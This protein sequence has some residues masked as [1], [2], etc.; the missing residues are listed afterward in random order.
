MRIIEFHNY[1][2]GCLDYELNPE[3][4]GFKHNI[5]KDYHL[6]IVWEG[7]LNKKADVTS[8]LKEK[9][10]II[11]QVEVVWSKSKIYENV[12]RFYKNEQSS[13]IT[14]HCK[15][16][17]RDGRFYCIVVEDKQ[18]VYNY[19]QNVSGSIRIVNTSILDTKRRL[20]EMLDGNYIHSSGCPEEFY[21]QLFLL[22]DDK[23]IKSVF[24]TN[25]KEH[26]IKVEQDLV[27]SNG[28]LDFEQFFNVINKC[29]NYL[30]QRN[31]EY[32][33][34]DFFGNDT[35]VDILCENYKEFLLA[36][37]GRGIKNKSRIVN[38]INIDNVSVQ[39]DIRCVS[40]KYY[41]PIW[42]A[43]MLKNKELFNK[44]VFS[45]SRYD[46]F[47]SL[48]YHSVIQKPKV[49]DVYVERLEGL[50]EKMGLDFFSKQSFTS[51]EIK[52]KIVSGYLGENGYKIYEAED[53][54]VYL[55]RN[56]LKFM[57][58]DLIAFKLVGTVEIIKKYT[59]K[60]LLKFTP[61]PLKSLIKRII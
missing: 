26:V 48:Y 30:V 9:F 58:S 12:S 20:R 43:K 8:K 37:N 25:Q 10:N 60:N 24:T 4:N 34:F 61:K 29:S 15:N 2:K 55:N 51:D 23:V 13:I 16:K 40:D 18:P 42:S 38:Y 35:D 47:F 19:R 32:L 3:N 11:S 27:G 53:A 5:D 57:P 14:E 44:I 45:P 59:P 36:S 7:G 49:K 31:F 6:F 52:A 39:F 33:P 54:T 41:D 22:F 28:W 21:E 17:V 46:Y 1:Y 50:S 56:V